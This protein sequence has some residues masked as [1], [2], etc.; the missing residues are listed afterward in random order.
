MPDIK[1][2]QAT[3]RA[4]YDAKLLS[5]AV[6]WQEISDLD[7]QIGEKMRAAYGAEAQLNAWAPYL[8]TPPE[9]TVTEQVARLPE[10][11]VRAARE[12]EE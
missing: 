7:D 1:V 9:G 3:A 4:M 10:D 11:A 8:D 12:Q 2:D 5:L 6:L